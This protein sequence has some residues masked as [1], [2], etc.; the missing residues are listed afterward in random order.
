MAAVTYRAGRCRRARTAAHFYVD[1]GWL[2]VAR[3]ISGHKHAVDVYPQPGTGPG[4]AVGRVDY[5][6]RVYVEGS[7]PN[8]ARVR[9]LG[10]ALAGGRGWVPANAVA[11][12]AAKTVGSDQELAGLFAVLRDA[13]FQV[14][15]ADVPIPYRY[16]KD[17][18]YARA[19]VMA[20]LLAASPTGATPSSA[21]ESRSASNSCRPS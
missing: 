8:W 9:I 10:G 4:A 17:G 13:T 2:S 18:C 14:N 11:E 3:E 16:P 1:E 15:G 19:E 7:A 6:A 20:G 12:V 21:A 5:L